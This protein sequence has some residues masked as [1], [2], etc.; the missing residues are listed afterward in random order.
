MS[1]ANWADVGWL[2]PHQTS[3]QEIAN[4]L[5]IV[6]RE[7]ADSAV[8]QISLDARLGML[9]NASL[10]LA[11]IALRTAGY[12]PGRGQSQHYRTIMSLPLTL[13]SEW[14]DAAEFL[15]GIRVLRNKAEYESVGFA[16]E[17]QFTELHGFVER[18][19]KAVARHTGTN[20]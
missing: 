3:R 17:R 19:R 11:D 10:K 2:R 8:S 12:R 4:L 7:L 16:T 1:L 13:G 6:E 15:D 20:R 14:T 18:L 5:A 9:Y